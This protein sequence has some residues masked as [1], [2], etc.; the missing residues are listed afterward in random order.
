MKLLEDDIE[1]NLDNL[2]EGNDFLDTRPKIQ[3][4][5]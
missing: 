5:K 1:E 4:M 3:S 2:G